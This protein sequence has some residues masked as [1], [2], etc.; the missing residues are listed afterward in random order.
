MLRDGSQWSGG[1]SPFTYCAMPAV[2]EFDEKPANWKTLW[3]KS[4]RQE[5]E[6]GRTGC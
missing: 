6:C 3:A 1:K 4:D 2:L 5:N